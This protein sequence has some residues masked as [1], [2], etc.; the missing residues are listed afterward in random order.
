[1][2]VTLASNP[3]DDMD[4]VVLQSAHSVPGKSLRAFRK[5]AEIAMI[6]I[7][8]SEALLQENVSSLSI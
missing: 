7:L 8:E 5:I 3:S 1:M 2:F 6:A 4:C